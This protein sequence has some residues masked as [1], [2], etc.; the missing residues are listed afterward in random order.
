[1]VNCR[2]HLAEGSATSSNPVAASNKI[3]PST[4]QLEFKGLL[5]VDSFDFVQGKLL[6]LSNRS[7]D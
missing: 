2:Y 7:R 3:T 4:L 5:R 6:A 1:M